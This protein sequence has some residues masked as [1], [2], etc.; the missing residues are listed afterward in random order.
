MGL[1]IQ[2]IVRNAGP[3]LEPIT[4]GIRMGIIKF[5]MIISGALPGS[6]SG[7]N[8]VIQVNNA[9]IPM[10]NGKMPPGG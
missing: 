4:I 1:Y 7:A 2:Q 8:V 3:L 6:D 10:T 9:V 5:G